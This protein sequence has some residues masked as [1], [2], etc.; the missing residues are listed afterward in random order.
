MGNEPLIII[1]TE[2]ILQFVMLSIPKEKNP[3]TEGNGYFALGFSEEFAPY[4]PYY[5]QSG[6]RVQVVASEMKLFL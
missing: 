4:R 2:S 5:M 6:Y 3:D 1:F